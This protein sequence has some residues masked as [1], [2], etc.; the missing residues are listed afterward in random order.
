VLRRRSAAARALCLETLETRNLLATFHVANSGHDGNAGDAASPWQTLQKAANSVQAGDTVIVRAGSYAGFHLTRDGTAASRITFSAEAGATITQRNPT[1][2][3]GINLEGADYITIEGFTVIGMPRAG[4][5]SVT[6]HHVIIRNNHCDQNFKWG[7][8]TGFSD[9]ILIE[10]NVTTRSTDEHGIYFSNSADRPVIRN[11]V[12]SGNRANGIH[13]N[14]DASLG[15]DGIISSALV[16]GNVLYDNGVGGGSG[17][18]CDGVQNSIIRNNLIYNTHASG[19]SLYRIDGG[20]GSSGN[21]VVNNTVIVAADGRWAL[22]IQSGSTG[23]TVRNNIFYTH[24]SFRGSLDISADSL[25]GFSSDYNVVMNRFTTNGGGSVQSLAQ[26]QAASGQDL[27]SLVAVPNQLFVN[28]ATGDFHLSEASPALDAGTMQHAPVVDFEGQARPSGGGID[29][30]ADERSGGGPPP[31]PPPPTN[32]APTNVAISASTVK[33]NSAAGTAIGWLSVSD[34]DAGDSHTLAL[35]DNAGGRFALSGNQLVVAGAI[36][37]EA[38]AS[39]TI[40]VRATDAGGLPFDKTIVIGVANIN[41]LVWINVQK[42]AAQR[43]YIRYVDLVFE[44]SA[45]LAQ[46]ISEGR[47]NLTRFGLW[48]NNPVNVPLGG[49]LKVS[50]NR[51]VADFGTNGIGGNRNSGAG[52]GYYRFGVDADRNGSKET[53]KH[54]Y[55]LLGDTN[56][57]RTVNATDQANVNADQNK[58]GSNL[59]SDVNGDGVVNATDRNHVKAQLGRTLW[60]AL[61]LDD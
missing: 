5:R 22:N 25:A 58:R 47:I 46:L 32:H 30:G 13:M 43:S 36:N 28:P 40:V 49:K 56:G 3:D 54:F 45:G 16:E 15:G 2:P 27:H 38:G 1:T 11:N 61:P 8:L 50:G 44:S 19:I 51:I 42:G 48:G 55:R 34:P 57:D 6:N 59:R 21:L 24:H 37:Y 7:I 10:G 52:N 18:N 60:S 9:D 23:N 31:P 26:W 41:E 29:I 33:E 17:I 12:S 35:V 14:G 39:Q 53:Q 4:I 20:G